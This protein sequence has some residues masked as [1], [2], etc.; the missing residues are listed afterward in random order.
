MS[1]TKTKTLK[2][3][4]DTDQLSPADVGSIEQWENEGGTPDPAPNYLQCLAPLRKGEIFEVLGG[5]IMYEDGK[6]FFR[7][8]IN[9]LS[10]R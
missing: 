1:K 4:L 6:L 5:E 7:A 9:I 8:E 10:L 2:I 3:A